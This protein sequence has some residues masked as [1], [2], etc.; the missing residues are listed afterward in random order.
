MTKVGKNVRGI[1]AL[2]FRRPLRQKGAR[3]IRARKS[4]IA[5]IAA[6]L[7]LAGVGAVL[8]EGQGGGSAVP[9]DASGNFEISGVTVDVKGKDAEAARTGGWRLAQRKGWE[10]LS[11]RLTGK[12]T[13]LSDS[14][15]DSVVSGIV[16]EKEQIGPTRYIGRLGVLFDRS[17]VGAMLGVSVAV[18]QSP[19]MLIVPL[20]YS[21]GAGIVYE[22]ETPWAQAWNRF[23]SGGSTIDYVRVRGTGPD[24]MLVNAGQVERRGR[25]WW[26]SVLDQYGAADVLIA[27]VQLR[28]EYPGGPVVGIFSATHGPDRQKIA[29]FALRVDAAGS[30]DALMDAGVE[31]LDKAFQNALAAGILHTDPMLSTRPP[32]PKAE[33]ETPDDTATDTP[34]PLAEATAAASATALSIQFD[35]PNAGAVTAGEAALRGVPGVRS[36]LTSSLALGGV[37]VMRVT[38]DGPIASLRSALEARGWQVQE[39]AGVLRIRRGGGAVPERAPIPRPSEA[40]TGG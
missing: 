27:E 34:T 9:I 16:V 21:G 23:R 39:G 11:R 30:I 3:M 31:R 17:K 7:A 13:G 29:D 24:A 5:G 2:G 22:R 18:S 36:A 15:L 10:M 12:A 8:A 1:S 14:A 19:P 26:R 6:A 33:E 32:Q 40:P 38:F 20:V 4:L 35:T 28:R 37:S 25:N